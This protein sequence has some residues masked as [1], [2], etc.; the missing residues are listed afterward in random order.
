MYYD[1]DGSEITANVFSSKSD[2]NGFFFLQNFA[3]ESTL[4]Q[5]VEKVRARR[6]FARP[7]LRSN[8]LVHGEVSGRKKSGIP[9]VRAPSCTYYSVTYYTRYTL[10]S[11]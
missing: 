11:V 7:R 9:S 3:F 1:V 10:L 8:F 2:E 6:L 5:K 4:P